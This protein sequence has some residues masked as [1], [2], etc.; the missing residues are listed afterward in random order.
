M[1]SR[2]KKNENGITLIALVVTIVILI[3]LATISINL[4]L[5]DGG[6]VSRSQKSGEEYKISGAREKLDITLGDA[7]IEKRINKKYNQ[8]EFLDEFIRKSLPQVKI[9]GDIVIVDGY[10]F[11]IDRSVP[12]I[13]KYIGKETQLIFPKLDA[14]VNNAS[15]NASAIITITA[16]E[17]EKGINKI[18]IWQE[19]FQI[20]KYDYDHVKEQIVIEYAAKQNGKY[21]IRAYGELV[22][23]KVI[24]VDGILAN[25]QYS[26]NGNETYKK[27]HTVKVTADEEVAK[28]KNIKYQWLETTAEPTAD[29]FVESCNNGDTIT[30]NEITGK[31]YLWT[32][33]ETE[34]G[35]TAIGRSEAFYFDNAG[36]EVELTSNPVSETSFT[37][38]ATAHDN[39]TKVVKYEFYVNDILKET[40][41][42]EEET[43][44]Y[45]VT[46][47]SMGDIECYVIVTDEL[48]N[49]SRA[50]IIG[51]T[52]QYVWERWNAN[53]TTNYKKQGTSSN[54][55]CCSWCC[56]AYDY[57]TSI[58]EC[59]ERRGW[60]TNSPGGRAGAWCGLSVGYVLYPTSKS[61]GVVSC[62]RCI[63]ADIGGNVC[64]Y[65]QQVTTWKYVS[66]TTYSKGT[67]QYSDVT[68]SNSSQYPNNAYQDGYW[69][70]YKGIE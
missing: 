69:Y 24:E 4:I 53:A 57:K 64:Y 68:S 40:I 9:G 28:V 3:I 10:A 12:K 1:K 32:L 6:L 17:K 48:G 11:E 15:N 27:E 66:D 36:P 34:N 47:V 25:V 30:K 60:Y 23:S 8:N 19:G 55:R 49:T 61:Q 62:M 16:E 33:L 2:S 31:W 13:G 50:T 56:L 29:S 21:E 67:T 14:K 41:N 65:T 37:L 39:E 59:T 70:V 52:K 58:Y 26:P 22:T 54:V 46:E 43:A 63:S 18:E 35:K 5:G 38:T 45:T 7:Q 20:E 51:K 42:I 44:N